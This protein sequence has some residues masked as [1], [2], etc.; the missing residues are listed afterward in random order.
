MKNCE[1]QNQFILQYTSLDQHKEIIM[2]EIHVAG[3]AMRETG[4]RS[5]IQA[6]F[7]VYVSFFFVS[8]KNVQWLRYMKCKHVWSEGS[9]P[10]SRQQCYWRVHI[11]HPWAVTHT[12]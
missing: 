4:K 12:N 10:V 8:V 6:F 2:K 3:T 5:R 11:Y 1:I 9:T 7:E